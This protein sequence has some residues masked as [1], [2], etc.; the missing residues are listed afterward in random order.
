MLE[1][2]KRHPF[3]WATYVWNMFDFAADAR[4]QGGEPGMNH[5]GLV[6]FD[7]KTKKDCFYLYKAYWSDDPFVY[8]AGRRRQDREEK[9]TEIRVY[10]NEPSVT[11]Y[12]NGEKQETQEGDKVFIF[13]VDLS[14]ETMVKV[15]TENASDEVTFR[16]VMRPNPEYRLKKSK[17]KSANWV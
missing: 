7:R 17:G 8:I 1:C 11:L 9:R 3:M 6:T 16:K 5:K 12:V 10:T 4:D 15:V 13:K 2:F 14:G